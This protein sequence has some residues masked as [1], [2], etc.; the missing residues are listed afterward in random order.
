MKTNLIR[1]TILNF[2]STTLN[3]G[4]FLFY[5]FYAI[6]LIGHSGYGEISYFQATIAFAQSFLTL[7]IA[8]SIT[9][10]IAA[11]E[12]EDKVGIAQAAIVGVISIYLVYSAIYMFY[13]VYIF[14]ELTEID[15]YYL[16]TLFCG[17]MTVVIKSILNG[18]Q[19]FKTPALASCLTT[20][21][22]V[23]IIILLTKYSGIQGG[24]LSIFI[25]NLI[26]LIFLCVLNLKQLL[27]IISYSITNLKNKLKKIINT[28]LPN[29]LASICVGFGFWLS[30]Y[31]LKISDLS[32]L[33][34][35]NA[36]N[37]WFMAIY[38]IPVIVAQVVLP[39]LASDK[40]Q[41]SLE[42]V[43]T[44]T[45]FSFLV[46][47]LISAGVYVFSDY[48]LKYYELGGVQFAKDAFLIALVTAV[49]VSIQVQLDHFNVAIGRSWLHFKLNLIWAVFVVLGLFLIKEVT[50]LNVFMIKGLAYLLRLI[51]LLAILKVENDK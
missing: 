31:S 46:S 30:M 24:I 50:V 39:K 45:A 35:H 10:E 41:D 47:T 49:L 20:I 43:K 33:G 34:I 42:F 12:N 19:D 17:T 8:V 36:I 5:S 15:I 26:L 38:F 51:I 23:P 7:G 2:F 6:N 29:F 14:H 3:K 16:I 21:L 4:L 40:P 27:D 37:Q 48:I 13:R 28:G 18:Y 9:R 44:I 25:I 11:S 32:Q 1:N 22:S